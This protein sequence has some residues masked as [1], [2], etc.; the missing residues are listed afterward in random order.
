MHCPIC[1]QQQI[2]REIR[3]CSRCGFEM[4][5]VAA[6]IDG[7]GKPKTP[8]KEWK[9]SPRRKGIYQGLFI[10]LLSFLIV[11][12]VAL[13]TMAANAEPFFVAAFA[14]ILTV[15]GILRVAYALMFESSD[16]VASLD[17]K[18]GSRSLLP[19]SGAKVKE[20]PPET[21]IPANVYSPPIQGAWRDTN[22]LEG[23]PGSVTENTTKLL[24]NDEKP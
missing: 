24:E 21:S 9:I 20:L 10:F 13:L 16:P 11:P 1:G 4:S 18:E 22:E 5:G 23:R 7:G 15:G 8:N 14:I 2:S 3:F 6:L 19:K 17:D 12:L